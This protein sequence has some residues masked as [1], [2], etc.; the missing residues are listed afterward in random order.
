[1]VPQ[2]AATHTQALLARLLIPQATGAG[3]DLTGSPSTCARPFP[4][5]GHVL[6][7]CALPVP[8][9]ASNSRPSQCFSSLHP[10]SEHPK[11]QGLHK[12]LPASGTP[13]LKT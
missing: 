1:M 4:T 7:V 8:H 2:L 9:V 11:V 10:N 6:H 5:P 13:Q 3:A 12:S